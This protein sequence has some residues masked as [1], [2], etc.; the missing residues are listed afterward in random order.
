MNGRTRRLREV[1]PMGHFVPDPD[2]PPDPEHTPDPHQPG[3][4]PSCPGCLSD[5][6]CHSADWADGLFPCVW[7][8]ATER[9]LSAM[10]Y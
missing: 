9:R 10:G 1:L 2:T 5:C 6:F 7:C 4:Q 8:Q 3:T